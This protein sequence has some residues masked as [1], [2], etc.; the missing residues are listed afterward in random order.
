VSNA[1]T[2]YQLMVILLHFKFQLKPSTVNLVS[3]TRIA[4]ITFG[5]TLSCNCCVLTTMLSQ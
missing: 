2:T 1:F 4:Y 5:N 3:L